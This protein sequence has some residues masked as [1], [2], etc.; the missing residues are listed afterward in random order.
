MKGWTVRY[1]YS[2]LVQESDLDPDDPGASTPL[3]VAA[4]WMTEPENCN[5]R[6]TVTAADSPAVP[7]SRPG[8]TLEDLHND[9]DALTELVRL[10][11]WAADG[12]AGAP[13]PG[14]KRTIPPESVKALAWAKQRLAETSN[15]I[16]ALEGA[17]PPL[18]A[19]VAIC[20]VCE[21]RPSVAVRVYAGT[22]MNVCDECRQ[23]KP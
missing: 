1:E 13:L 17:G 6:I 23:V 10:A 11:A 12:Q 18:E 2:M 4:R 20:D 3:Q 22:E 15:T 16:D 5:P 21:E 8:S 19:T 9:A 14:K 7:I